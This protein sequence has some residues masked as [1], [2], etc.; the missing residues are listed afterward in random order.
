MNGGSN[1]SPLAERNRRLRAVTLTWLLFAAWPF[2][3]GNAYILSLGIYFFINLLLIGGLNLAMGYGGQISLAQ[4]GF[5]GIG[6]YL[7]G[8]LSAKYGWPPALTTIVAVAG[9]AT[10]AAFIG[11]PA[12]RLTGH[13]LAMATLGF[14]AILA[15]LFNELVTFTGGPNG[16]AAIPPIAFGRFAF[17]TPARFFWLAWAAGLAAMLMLALLLASRPGRAL[18]AVAA[19]EIAADSMGVDP[20]ATKLIA[21]VC[22][23][24]CAALAGALYAHFNQYVSPETFGISA[25]VLMVV[26]VALG[27]WGRYW[28]APLGALVFTGVPELLVKFQDAELLVFGL[29]MIV[30]MLFLPGGI[31]GG[32]EQAIARRR[33]TV[34]ARGAS[35]G[36]G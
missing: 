21:F 31:A 30:V 22:S 6:A 34:A 29:G 35:H 26:M 20:F 9:G 1:F 3:A 10:A 25:S 36:A 28:G 32:F 33:P 2:V 19:S 12:L 16:L 18:R 24:A 11:F 27:G 15:V 14:N 5:F 8:V 23:A 4:A 13:Y 17:D 7:S